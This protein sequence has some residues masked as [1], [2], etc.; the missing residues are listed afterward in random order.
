MT[1]WIPCPK[2]NGRGYLSMDADCQFCRASGNVPGPKDLFMTDQAA[3]LAEMSGRPKQS[4]AKTS[5]KP[6][7]RRPTKAQMQAVIQIITA[8]EGN[9]RPKR[10]TNWS[11]AKAKKLLAAAGKLV[12]HPPTEHQRRKAKNIARRQYRKNKKLAGQRAKAIFHK[13]V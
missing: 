13:V 9:L 4:A 5:P 12:Q 3:A 2:C 1:N 6:K 7:L 10:K 11:D 8:H